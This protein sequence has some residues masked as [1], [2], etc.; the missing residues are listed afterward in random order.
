MAA[1]RGLRRR[2]SSMLIS[3]R[4]TSTGTLTASTEPSCCD[5]PVSPTSGA[6]SDSTTSLD[7]DHFCLHSVDA[8]LDVDIDAGLLDFI[9]E[10]VSI[11]PSLSQLPNIEQLAFAKYLL[12]RARELQSQQTPGDWLRALSLGLA[13]HSKCQCNSPAPGSI[14]TESTHGEDDAAGECGLGIFGVSSMRSASISSESS[15]YTNDEDFNFSTVSLPQIQDTAVFSSSSSLYSHSGSEPDSPSSSYTALS[16]TLHRRASAPSLF[17]SS[18]SSSS[19]DAWTAYTW[20]TCS[21]HSSPRGTPRPGTASSYARLALVPSF[22]SAAPSSLSRVL[23]S[24]SSPFCQ[25][26]AA[27]TSVY[28]PNACDA[29]SL[30][31]HPSAAAW[32]V[33]QLSFC[34]VKVGMLGRWVR[35]R[36]QRQVGGRVRRGWR[37]VRMGAAGGK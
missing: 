1:L 11:H 17:S 6:T 29:L 18:T 26:A 23:S 16:G 10:E 25:A 33:A 21:A 36:V 12:G 30:C 31:R 13:L 34:D 37:R 2:L 27:Y 9:N 22:A 20:S 15:A 24:S 32:S 19:S 5:S 14:E 4:N 7:P 35:G 28:S 8:P 3:S